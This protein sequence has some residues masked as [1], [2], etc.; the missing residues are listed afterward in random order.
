MIRTLKFALLAAFLIG[1]LDMAV[2][3]TL[4]APAP[5]PTKSAAVESVQSK[6]PAY[7]NPAFMIAA[8][9]GM[10][11]ET[12]SMWLVAAN[13]DTF[14]DPAYTALACIALAIL[15]PFGVL[16]GLMRATQ[17]DVAVQSKVLDTMK[18]TGAVKASTMTQAAASSR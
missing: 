10:R 15:I 11:R 9:E 16:F 14:L 6:I 8:P 13:G 4:D 17:K 5:A 18:A 1:L 2:R 3:A 12:R 7:L